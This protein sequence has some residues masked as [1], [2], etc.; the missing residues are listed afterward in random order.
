MPRT[1]LRHACMLLGTITPQPAP[2]PLLPQKESALARNTCIS[3]TPAGTNMR[4]SHNKT[5]KTTTQRIQLCRTMPPTREITNSQSLTAPVVVVVVVA[6]AA[7]VAVVHLLSHNSTL[8]PPPQIPIITRASSSPHPSS[9]MSFRPHLLKR[10]LIFP[11]HPWTRMKSLMRKHPPL[12]IAPTLPLSLFR[13]EVPIIFQT[14]RPSPISL[15]PT[16][17]P[18]VRSASNWTCS[19]KMKWTMRERHRERPLMSAPVTAR[20]RKRNHPTNSNL[21]TAVY[22]RAPFHSH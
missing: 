8:S 19:C 2:H 15:P 12:Q 21:P 10:W 7:V 13:Q 18:N 11:C 4:Q 6:V 17:H 9:A 20:K 22:S 16:V 5:K 1:S 14:L 3:M